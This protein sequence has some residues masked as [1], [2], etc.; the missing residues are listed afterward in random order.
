[1]IKSNIK[2]SFECDIEKVWDIITNNNEYSWRSDIDRIEI[3]DDNNFIEYTK[4]NFPTNFKIT[5]KDN[6]KRYEFDIENKNIRG[7]WIGIFFKK[8]NGETQIDFTEEIE[9]NNVIMRLLA[10]SYLKRQQE[11]YIE[12]LRKIIKK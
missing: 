3:V 2:A 6:L 11:R 7:H 9:V 5:K 4:D 1:M 10:K 8:E 12:D